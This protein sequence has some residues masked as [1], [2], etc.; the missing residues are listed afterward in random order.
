MDFFFSQVSKS[1][2][3]VSYTLIYGIFV[4]FQ[5]DTVDI[6]LKM[7]QEITQMKLLRIITLVYDSLFPWTPTHT[8]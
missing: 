6:R 1:H 8:S 7:K 5:N 4:R 2:I 3:T